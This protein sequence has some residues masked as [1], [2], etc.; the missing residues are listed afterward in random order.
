[1]T[2]QKLGPFEL[3]RVLGRGGMGTVYEAQEKER[4]E[5][6]AVK[7]LAPTFSFDEHFRRRFEAEIDALL[8]LD[9]K[10]IVRLL[11][12][13]QDQ[14]NLYFAME[15]INGQSLYQEQKK[16]HVFHWQEIIEIGIQVCEG[17]RHAHERG[18][19]HR[20]LKPG[21]L[22]VDSHRNIKIAD[23]GIA[24]SFGKSSFTSEGNVLGTMDFMAPEQARGNHAD[25]RSDL[26]SLGAVMYSLLAG[27]PPF[28]KK[29]VDETF[30]ALLSAAPPP[31]LDQVAPDTPQ[32]LADLIHRLMEKEPQRR[33]ATA[34]AT[35]RQLAHVLG[36]I[37][38]DSRKIDTEVVGQSP[39]DFRLQSTDFG[40]CENASQVDSNDFETSENL[41]RRAG[42]HKDEI[43]FKKLPENKTRPDLS[44][45]RKKQPD[46]FNEV[47]QQQRIKTS[48]IPVNE[49][50]TG[51]VWP[52]LVA[53]LVV[54]AMLVGGAWFALRPPSR[55]DLLAELRA[56]ENSPTKIQDEIRQFQRWYADDTEIAFVN[57]LQTKAEIEK[58]CNSLRMRAR[59]SGKRPL[60]STEAMFLEY[61]EI[62]KT[63]IYDG[64]AQM[65]SLLILS[66]TSTAKRTDQDN[67]ALGM[68]E[69]VVIQWE[70]VAEDGI[71]KGTRQIKDGFRS[72]EN[73][74]SK[75]AAREIYESIIGIYSPQPWASELV[76]D[77]RRRLDELNQEE[78]NDAESEIDQ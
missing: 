28:L 44:E 60:S 33:I 37:Q 72:A 68:A 76:K 32:P 14:G 12:F 78:D 56:N 59:G 36:Q 3:I 73:S 9:H 67:K 65:R 30:E 38:V 11:S 50:D 55:D 46:Y 16:G 29:T 22:M 74:P 10:N 70:V 61:H 41:T 51:S 23:F 8:A 42:Q 45:V 58:Y 1:M 27:K 62:A 48:E 71:S 24:K 19:I 4:E 20:D 26:F 18:I 66:N 13:G 47:T 31:R 53:L 49:R 15:L 5:H 35:G 52:L 57:D 69:R 64:L 63:D 7:A 17:L 75:N 2:M 77:A 39:E 6:V 34:M 40:E 21:N 43:A 54:M 25:A